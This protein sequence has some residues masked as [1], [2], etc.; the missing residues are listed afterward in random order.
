MT[1]SPTKPPAP[2]ARSVADR[3][4][5]ALAKDWTPVSTYFLCNYHR[6]GERQAGAAALTHGEAMFVIHLIRFKW[7]KAMP[8]PGFKTLATEMGVSIPQARALARSVQRKGLLNR[9]MRE[10]TT[11]QFDLRPLFEALEALMA[12]DAKLKTETG[13]AKRKQKK[14]S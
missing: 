10:A 3:W 7:D 11:N 14:A 1:S 12:K 8:Y 13:A 5:P 4:T 2:N 9:V 6:L